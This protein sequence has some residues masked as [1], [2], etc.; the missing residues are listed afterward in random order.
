MKTLFLEIKKYLYIYISIYLSSIYH[1]STYRDSHK[2]T[3][4]YL[5]RTAGSLPAT[6]SRV[7]GVQTE[8]TV[9]SFIMYL[10][11]CTAPIGNDP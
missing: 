8:A 4:D 1:I 9:P 5:E 10:I 11:K 7:L 2:I 3:Q 6:T